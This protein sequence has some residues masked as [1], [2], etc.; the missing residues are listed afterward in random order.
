MT[1]PK[2]PTPKKVPQ[3]LSEVKLPFSQIIGAL[4][5]FIKLDP[6]QNAN[7]CQDIA[8]HDKLFQLGRRGSKLDKA[9]KAFVITASPIERLKEFFLLQ[10]NAAAGDDIRRRFSKI[11]KRLNQWRRDVREIQ[12]QWI[13]DHNK[14]ELPDEYSLRHMIGNKLC[15]ELEDVQFE[16]KQLRNA[17][18]HFDQSANEISQEK[19]ATNRATNL[20]RFTHCLKHPDPEIVAV[21]RRINRDKKDRTQ[22]S[23]VR[24]YLTGQRLKKPIDKDVSQFL[25]TMRTFERRKAKPK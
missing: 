5:W 24:E 19:H 18:R 17:I 9:E 1:K 16:A 11:Q 8:G 21:A 6:Y 4:D 20:Q 13:W 23:I 22:A 3:K 15:A 7:R 10:G 12:E 14:L 2:N 25:Q